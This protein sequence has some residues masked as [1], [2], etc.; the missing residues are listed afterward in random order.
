MKYILVNQN[1]CLFFFHFKKFL[2]TNYFKF[3]KKKKFDSF[4]ITLPDKSEQK[5]FKTNVFY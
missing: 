4:K 5:L 1:N 3:K 2:F